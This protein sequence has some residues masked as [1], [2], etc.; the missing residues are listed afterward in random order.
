[1]MAEKRIFISYRRSDTAGHAGRL[2]DYLKD[3]FGEERLFYD[4]DTI[5]PG[6]DF[7]RKI[8]TELEDSGVVLVMIGDRWLD[9]KDANGNKR[10]DDSHDYVRLEV[11]AALLKNV[12][13]IPVLLQGVSMPSGNELPEP[14]SDL[15]RRNAI[16]LSDENWNPDLSTLTAILKS[17][18]GVPGSLKEQRIKR[19]RQIVFALSLLAAILSITNNFFLTGSP[20]L[21][22][23]IVKFVYLILLSTNTVFI[24][25]LLVTMKR[26]LDRL[27]AVIIT[28]AVI[29][30]ML[31]AWGGSLSALTP[32]P[33][34]IV[35]WLINFVKPDE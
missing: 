18:L 6:V 14:L 31:V 34:L 28:M 23:G 11:E 21:I 13:V 29:A 1:M 7:E 4:V 5:K 30:Q 15:S 10:L 27:S 19:Y 22:R 17:I 26:A 20:A 8:R 25:Y 9:V 12:T 35:A 3:Y 33:L 16:R 2:Y 32:I 24:T